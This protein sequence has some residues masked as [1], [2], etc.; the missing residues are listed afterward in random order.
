MMLR[1]SEL[2]RSSALDLIL[3]WNLSAKILDSNTL[4]GVSQ[5]WKN[6]FGQMMFN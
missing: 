3:L 4:D 5:P 6:E 2:Y 1:N